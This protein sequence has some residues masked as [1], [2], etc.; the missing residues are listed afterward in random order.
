MSALGRLQPERQV[1]LSTRISGQVKRIYVQEG[2]YVEAGALLL[3]LDAPDYQFALDR[4]ERNVTQHQADLADAQQAPS[5]ASIEVAR[6][7]LRRATAVRLKAQQDYDDVA[8]KPGADKSDEL[9][10]LE[11]AKLDYE[12]AKAEFDRVMA[13][14]NEAQIERLRAELQDAEAS[15]RQAK[16][17]VEYRKLVAPWAGTV[18]RVLVREGENVG[19]YNALVR[20]ADVSSLQIIAQIDEI[21]IA[22]LAEGQAVNVRF[23]ALPTKSFHGKIKRIAP[24]ATEGQTATAY[25]AVVELESSDPALR[26]GMGAT[27]GI[28]TQVAEEVLLVPRRAVRQLGRYQVVR[29]VERGK[30]Q[31]TRIET[32]MVNDSSIQVLSGLREGQIVVLD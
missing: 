22:Q 32:G 7:G 18:M 2:Q 26:P 27:L 8:K 16:E 4:A 3:E 19:G 6:A 5:S 21:D 13:G 14:T 1:N 9:I 31:D 10:A 24:G 15:L 20:L 11:A 29:V 30:I 28:V 17:Q 12:V 25:E 23:D